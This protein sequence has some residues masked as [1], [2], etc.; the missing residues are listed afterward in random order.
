M[1]RAIYIATSAASVK[2]RQLEFINRNLA[3]LNTIGYKKERIAFSS[4]VLP[5]EFMFEASTKVMLNPSP[6]ITTDY[7]EGKLINTGNPLDLAL[8]GKGFFVLE[9]NRYTRRGDFRL[10]SEGYLINI[11]GMRVLGDNSMPIRIPSG[12]V[13]IAKDGSITV[14]GKRIA[15][16][17]IVDFAEPYRLLRIGDSLYIPQ[18]QQEPIESVAQVIQGSLEGSNVN[19]IS[20]MTRMIEATREFETFQKTIRAIDEASSKAINEIGRI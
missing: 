9:G 13:I 2:D 14:D 7:S 1:Y 20:E 11:D 5:K 18:G 15:R 3:N 10:D 12:K 16:L 17:K 6:I 4:F 8:K 19:I